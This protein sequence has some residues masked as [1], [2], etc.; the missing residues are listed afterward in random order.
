[1][2]RFFRALVATLLVCAVSSAQD[3]APAPIIE[4]IEI[5]V[6]DV[7]EE[8]GRTPDLWPYRTANRLHIETRESIIRQASLCGRGPS[9]HGSGSPNR[10]KL[11][12][13]T[14]LAKSRNR[15]DSHGGRARP[16]ARHHLRYM[17]DATRAS[18]GQSRERVDLGSGRVR[19]QPAGLWKAAPDTVWLRSGSRRD[20]YVVSR[21]S[22]LRLARHE[23]CVAIERL[24]RASR[25]PLRDPPVLFRSARVG[26]STRRSKTSIAST[27]YSRM[28]SVSLSLGTTDDEA[29]FTPPAP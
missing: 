13:F 7:F 22:N 6:E 21:S 14:F 17:V 27:H 2:L 3:E 23:P 28:A 11:A 12:R 1:M 4:S 10:A 29:S 24:R 26:A 18:F 8:N 9:R 19:D 15:N 20:F 25:R 16:C 5:Y